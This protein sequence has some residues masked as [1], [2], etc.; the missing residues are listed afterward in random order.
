MNAKE[1]AAAIRRGHT[2]IGESRICFLVGGCGCALGA[3]WVGS[4]RTEGERHSLYVNGSSGFA[5]HMGVESNLALEVSHKH[6]C[7]T[8]RLA[9]AD[10]LETLEPA[11]RQTFEDFMR[12]TMVA[13]EIPT[14]TPSPIAHK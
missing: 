13:V 6:F 4:G 11:Q 7:G 2:M 12:A 9:I 1:L 8:P 5:K 10:W 14:D 3:A